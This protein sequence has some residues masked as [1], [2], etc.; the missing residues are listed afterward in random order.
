MNFKPATVTRLDIIFFD[1][2]VMHIPYR[3]KYTC[4][5][6]DPPVII[7]E[8]GLVFPDKFMTPMRKTFYWYH[9][10]DEAIPVMVKLKQVVVPYIELIL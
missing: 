4:H 8:G 10:P 6:F 9:D 2:Q 3:K 1:G 5:A 7:T